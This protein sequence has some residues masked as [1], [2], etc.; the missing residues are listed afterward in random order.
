MKFLKEI[1]DMEDDTQLSLNYKFP[2]AL[3]PRIPYLP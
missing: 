3:A 2:I 1:L